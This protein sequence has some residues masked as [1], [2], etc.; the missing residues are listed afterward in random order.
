MVTELDDIGNL[1]FHHYC[2]DGY[3]IGQRL[4]HSN[5]I[6]MTILREPRVRP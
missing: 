1:V 3:P 5:D 4:R 6:R 2:S